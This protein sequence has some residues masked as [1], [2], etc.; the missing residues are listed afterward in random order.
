MGHPDDDKNALIGKTQLLQAFGHIKLALVVLL[1]LGLG[2]FFVELIIFAMADP[3][4][5]IAVG[6]G[7]GDEGILMDVKVNAVA[8]GLPSSSALLSP[9]REASHGSHK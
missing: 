8:A 2:I 7:F 1:D 3:I 9:S 4:D 5:G 6:N